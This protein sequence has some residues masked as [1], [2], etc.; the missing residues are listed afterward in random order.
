MLLFLGPQFILEEALLGGRGDKTQMIC[1]QPRRVAATSVAER[2]AE[3]MCDTLGNTVGYQIRMEAKKSA[4]TKLLF[5]TTGIVLRRLQDD[6]NLEGV[7]HCLVDEV[8]ERQQQTDVLLIIL[9]QLLCTTRRDL[10][11]ILMSATLESELF[12]SFFNNA[13][14]ISVPGRTFPVRDYFLEDILEATNHVIE[15][16]SRYA[17]F[18]GSYTDQTTLSITQQDGRKRKE[19]V[20]LTS[21][22]EPIEVSSLYETYSMSTRRSMERVSEEII[23]YDLIED[24]LK[25]LLIDKNNDFGADLSTGSTL[26]FLPGLGEIK[27]MAERL[28]GSRHFNRYFE[29]IPL[30]STLSSKDQRRAFLPSKLRKIS[31]CHWCSLF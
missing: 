22:T 7:T 17:K 5:C 10:K 13:P 11:V 19:V 12:C 20:D 31:K 28:E 8:H 15:E 26:V 16:G 25:H 14:L 6:Q 3:E 27:S 29:I 23:N 21:S 24:V 2:V 4:H 1:T 30:H 9:R 18:Q